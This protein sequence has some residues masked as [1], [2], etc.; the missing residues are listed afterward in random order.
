LEVRPS[1]QNGHKNLCIYRPGF[2]SIFSCV[3]SHFPLFLSM[4][5]FTVPSFQN[6]RLHWCY[7]LFL[8]RAFTSVPFRLNYLHLAINKLATP[9]VSPHTIW[10]DQTVQLEKQNWWVMIYIVGKIN[11]GVQKCRVNCGN[12]L[13]ACISFHRA[14]A[15]PSPSP[16]PP[17]PHQ[18]NP[19]SHPPKLF[20]WKSFSYL[21]KYNSLNQGVSST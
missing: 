14:P 5:L 15:L 16:V 12:D 8:F 19:T 9:S 6:L 13:Q 1:D 17:H 20:E 7:P 2:P 10:H 11:I 18:H 21:K 4:Y 3:D